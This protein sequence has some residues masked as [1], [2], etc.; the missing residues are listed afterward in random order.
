[1]FHVKQGPE[2]IPPG[3]QRVEKVLQDFFEFK[4]RQSKLPA[5]RVVLIS[6]LY[7]YVINTF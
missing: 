7:F 2:E 6:A 1:M 4:L 3:L 5:K